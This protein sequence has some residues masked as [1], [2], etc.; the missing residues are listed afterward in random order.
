MMA[1]IL[2]L[3]LL[4]SVP[5]MPPGAVLSDHERRGAVIERLDG[6]EAASASTCAAACGLNGGCMAWSWRPWLGERPGACALLGAVRPAVAA[7]GSVTGLSP[8]LAARIEAAGDRAP[9]ARERAALQ[10]LEASDAPR[11]P[12]RTS[13]REPGLAGG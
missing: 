10:A 8:Q 1:L 3:L 11:R 6:V 5:A 2:P 9:D 12:A 13:D 4:I 7:P